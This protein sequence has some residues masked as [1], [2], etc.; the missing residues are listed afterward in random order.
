M[1]VNGAD[2]QSL[3]DALL[4]QLTP[5]VRAAVETIIARGGSGVYAVGGAVRDLLLGRTVR[6]LDLVTERNAID[7]VRASLTEARITPHARFLT[8]TVKVDGTRIDVATCRTETY[9]RPGA[10][11]RVRPGAIG[12]DLRRRDFTINAMALRLD[13]AAALLDPAEGLDDLHVGVVRVLHDGSF[14]DD[15]T[16]I[17]RAFRYAARLGFGIDLATAALIERDKH[18]VDSLS[19]ERVRREIELLLREDMAASVLHDCDA[20]GVLRA[21]H[22]SLA[23]DES[24][25]DAFEPPPA[26]AVPRVPFGFALLSRNAD[27]TEAAEITARLRLTKDEAAAVAVQTRCDGSAPGAL[28]SASPGLHALPR[29]RTAP[30]GGCAVFHGDSPPAL[31][32][33]GDVCGRGACF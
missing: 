29:L 5:P 11:P 3:R 22:P 32:H 24:C 31:R 16:R 1:D 28:T 10:L 30:Y 13:G 6:D 23:W 9:P 7:L 2:P 15:A 8:A 27:A 12:D 19:G 4:R 14:R 25:R 18:Y 26:T 21:V 33:A 17:F 20:A